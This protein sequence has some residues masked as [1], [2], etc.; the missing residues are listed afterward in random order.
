[1]DS[2]THFAIGACIGEAFAGKKIGKKA[3]LMGAGAQS[4]PDIDFIASFWLDPAHNVLAHRG[5]THSIL[6]TLL[7]VPI[8]A[9]LGEK[10]ERKNILS[11]RRWNYFF[12]LQLFTHLFLD[13][14][15]AYG[16]GWFEPFDHTRISFHILF[17]ADPLFSIF[18]AIA[19][20]GLLFAGRN[21]KKIK[22]WVKFGLVPVAIYLCWGIYNKAIV[23]TDVKKI[24]KKQNIEYQRHFTTPTPF[25][26]IVWFVVLEVDS[27]YQIAHRATYANS[28]QIKFYYFPRN[29]FLLDSIAYRPDVILLKRFSQGYYTIDRW[30]DTL[31]FNDLRFGQVVGWHNPAGRFAFHYYLNPGMD[32]LLVIPRG[33][34]EGWDVNAVRSL[35]GKMFGD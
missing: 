13:A 30:K 34:F 24:A 35:I 23:E 22:T 9:W 8:L 25:N 15:N 32:N 7:A 10:L 5:F 27:G 4:L 33:R 20:F 17:V 14:F 18:P 1:M 12:A 2:L 6:F 19:F 11:Y 28:S 31:V 21:S 16:V 3:M 26:N 29:E